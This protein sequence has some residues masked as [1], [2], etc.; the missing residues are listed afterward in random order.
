MVYEHHLK[1]SAQFVEIVVSVDKFV[2]TG[3]R[4]QP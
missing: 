3:Q 4:D 2:A 1:R